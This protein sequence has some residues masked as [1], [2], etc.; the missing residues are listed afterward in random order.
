[1]ALGQFV[2]AHHAGRRR[3][4]PILMTALATIVGMLPLALGVDQGRP[5][6]RSRACWA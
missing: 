3:L 1:M 6:R 5:P 2:E 4:R